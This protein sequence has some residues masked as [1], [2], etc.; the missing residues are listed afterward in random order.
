MFA[1]AGYTVVSNVKYTF[2]DTVSISNTLSTDSVDFCGDKQLEF[3]LNGTTKTYFT[4]SNADYMY[5]SPPGNTSDFG[6][7]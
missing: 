2:S 7:G 1:F 4:A 3:M 6:V 5:F